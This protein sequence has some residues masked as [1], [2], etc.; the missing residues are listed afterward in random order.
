MRIKNGQQILNTDPVAWENQYQKEGCF[1]Q[2]FLWLSLKTI[3]RMPLKEALAA[4]DLFLGNDKV[5]PKQILQWVSEHR[6]PDK[7]VA[8]WLQPDFSFPS[9]IGKINAAHW[10]AKELK[11]VRLDIEQAWT[12]WS[13]LGEQW[14]TF[15]TNLK[16]DP[17]NQTMIHRVNDTLDGAKTEGPHDF[18][19]YFQFLTNLGDAPPS[20]VDT[21]DKKAVFSRVYHTEDLRTLGI[22]NYNDWMW[23]LSYIAPRWPEYFEADPVFE[24]DVPNEFD[25]YL[26]TILLRGDG[27]AFNY[28]IYRLSQRGHD[29]MEPFLSWF[30]QHDLRSRADVIPLLDKAPV[31][32]RESL[33]EVYLLAS[34]AKSCWRKAS[35]YSLHRNTE[36]VGYAA[37]RQQLLEWLPHYE[38]Q[39]EQIEYAYETLNCKLTEQYPYIHENEQGAFVREM[40]RLWKS[41]GL[42][43]KA[44]VEMDVPANTFETLLET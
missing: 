43:Q 11:H 5:P 3:P 41:M 29:A 1:G 20:L 2:R 8:S 4:I 22:D 24:Q 34:T 7:H 39:L 36:Y 26:W 17:W 9:R 14:S 10:L 42:F 44:P 13:L 12:I 18:R 32:H 35:Y 40:L 38:A 28:W 37:V 21:I 27:G 25:D 31:E 33:L 30:E 23:Q 6:I 19:K 15:V 16:G